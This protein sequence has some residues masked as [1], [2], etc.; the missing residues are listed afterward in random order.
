MEGALKSDLRCQKPAELAPLVTAISCSQ[1]VPS[2]G[3]TSSTSRSG[4]RGPR[5]DAHPQRGGGQD[6]WPD[7]RSRTRGMCSIWLPDPD[8]LRDIADVERS[9]APGCMRMC[10]GGEPWVVF[11]DVV[12]ADHHPSRIP[13]GGSLHSA[14]RNMGST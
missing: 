6:G 1:Q 14:A 4:V 3:V 11:E 12:P 5:G 13:A 8:P 2:D 10:P 7:S 9:D